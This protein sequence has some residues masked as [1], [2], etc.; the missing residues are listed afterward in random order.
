MGV[1]IVGN[2]YFISLFRLIGIETVAAENEDSVV[3]KADGVVE[4]GQYE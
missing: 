2:K 3:I 4:D 1:A